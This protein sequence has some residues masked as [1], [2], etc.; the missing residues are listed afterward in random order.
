MLGCGTSPPD[1]TMLGQRRDNNTCDQDRLTI[2][3]YPRRM[4]IDG[5]ATRQLTDR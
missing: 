1:V 3:H 5:I 2:L 4:A